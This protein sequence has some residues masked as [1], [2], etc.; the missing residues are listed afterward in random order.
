[1]GTVQAPAEK[2]GLTF[3]SLCSTYPANI[4]IDADTQYIKT[5][6]ARVDCNS[7]VK[8]LLVLAIITC[9][10]GIELNSENINN[11]LNTNSETYSI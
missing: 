4:H 5:R 3:Q 11:I 8:L 2:K 6:V 7:L 10:Q 1:M 9:D